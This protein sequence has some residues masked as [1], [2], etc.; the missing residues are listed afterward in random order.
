MPLEGTF[1]GLPMIV[2][3]ILF[4]RWRSISRKMYVSAIA[5]TDKSCFPKTTKWLLV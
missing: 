4:G 5:K 2:M 1:K 3:E